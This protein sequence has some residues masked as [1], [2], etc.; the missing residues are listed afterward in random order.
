[1]IN[2][3]LSSK[4]LSLFYNLSLEIEMCGFCTCLFCSIVCN[5]RLSIIMIAFIFKSKSQAKPTQLTHNACP[6]SL[7]SQ[8]IFNIPFGIGCCLQNKKK[9]IP[10]EKPLPFQKQSPL[11]IQKQTEDSQQPQPPTGVGQSQARRNENNRG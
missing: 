10:P 8:K 1:M 3:L 7:N 4:K 9:Q 11:T 2:K 6:P 5:T